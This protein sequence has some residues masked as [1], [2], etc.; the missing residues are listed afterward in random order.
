[1]TTTKPHIRPP[2]A[3]ESLQACFVE[4]FSTNADQ[5]HDGVI[6]LSLRR[7][8]ISL[9][10]VVVS[11]LCAASPCICHSAFLSLVSP[12]FPTK[13][14]FTTGFESL[15]AIGFWRCIM[16]PTSPKCQM[17]QRIVDLQTPL[18]LLRRGV[19]S[20]GRCDVDDCSGW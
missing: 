11:A 1:M 19:R 13:G 2:L 15:Y 18:L 20:Q 9:R 8:A 14:M 10:T 3:R 4:N 5:E 6:Q 17:R 12:P 16:T 7:W